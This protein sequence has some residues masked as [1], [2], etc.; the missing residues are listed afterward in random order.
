MADPVERLPGVRAALEHHQ[1]EQ[2]RSQG[3]KTRNA[4]DPHFKQ[5][6][7]FHSS[8]RPA[9]AGLRRASSSPAKSF[10]VIATTCS[11][12][13]GRNTLPARLSYRKSTRCEPLIF[14]RMRNMSCKGHDLPKSSTPL[15][16]ELAE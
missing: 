16:Y 11:K 5:A 1:P 3:R 12:L 10:A 9:D 8:E 14:T 6:K 15:P 7:G 4:V 2:Q 13:P